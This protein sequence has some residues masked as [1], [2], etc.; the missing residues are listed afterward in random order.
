LFLKEPGYGRLDEAAGE[1]IEQLLDFRAYRS[2]STPF[3]TFGIRFE[4]VFLARHSLARGF[5]LCH[6]IS[7]TLSD[8]AQAMIDREFS[9]T[10]Q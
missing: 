9:P 5:S 2:F 3:R 7:S 1:F 6:F 4:L 8:C 10:R